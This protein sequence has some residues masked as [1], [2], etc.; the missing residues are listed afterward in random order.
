VYDV[1]LLLTQIAEKFDQDGKLAV[2]KK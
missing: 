2:I 1:D